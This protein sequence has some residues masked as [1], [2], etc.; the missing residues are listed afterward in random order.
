MNGG[1]VAGVG[2]GAV[3]GVVGGGG[4]VVVVLVLVSWC[5]CSVPGSR[6]AHRPFKL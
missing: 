3:G 6:Q 2:V 1:S 5:C 4:V